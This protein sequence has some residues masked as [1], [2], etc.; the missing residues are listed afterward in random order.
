MIEQPLV[1][2]LMNCYNGEK[3]LK[4]AIDS[5]YAQTY[6]NWEIIFV[7]NCSTDSTSKIA[8]SY[9]DGKLKY[10]KTEE[11]IS[12]YSARNFGLKYIEGD[13]LA[14]LDTDDVW[15]KDKLE[16]QINYMNKHKCDLLCTNIN[17]YIK[18]KLSWKLTQFITMY[19]MRRINILS[20]VDLLLKYNINLQTVLLEYKN[21]K[22]IIK[23]D[24]K[25]NH[26]GDSEL[27]LRMSFLKK[28]VVYINQTTSITRLHEEQLS[29]KSME[30]WIVESK[31]VVQKL[32]H[33]LP[34][35]KLV[36][37]NYFSDRYVFL[38]YFYKKDFK[39]A[40][41]V[42]SKYKKLGFFPFYYYIKSIFYSIK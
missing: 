4:E 22:E 41:K 23:F 18:D 34:E 17:I 42:I 26:T 6:Q 38:K 8:Q 24:E 31:Y 36:Y 10:Y 28:R 19:K 3:Y 29:N 14:F 37:L 16:I 9:S 15:I 33:L 1:S 12:L 5:I 39:N 27:F 35:D 7:D 11:N 40:T 2:I 13:Y 32:S 25:L 20:S 21:N 30:N